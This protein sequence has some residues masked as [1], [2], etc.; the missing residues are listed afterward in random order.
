M[1]NRLASFAYAWQGLRYCFIT[2]PNLRIQLLAAICVLFLA[3][4]HGLSAISKALL[5][6]TIGLVIVSE[7]INTAIEKLADVVAPEYHSG[8]KIVKDVAAAAVLS[9][10]VLAVAIG[11]QLFWGK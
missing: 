11:Y 9:A 10:A 8:I 1:R 6:L 5:L 7:L 3:D 4:Y 2:Q